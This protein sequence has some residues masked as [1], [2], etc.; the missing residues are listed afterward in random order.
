[1]VV[2]LGIVV[3]SQEVMLAG[4]LRQVTACRRVRGVMGQGMV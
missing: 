3:V 1:M 4:G 2:I